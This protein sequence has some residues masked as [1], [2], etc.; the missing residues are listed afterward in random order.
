MGRYEM[1]REVS[2]EVP[3]HA[4]ISGDKQIKALVLVEC[5]RC[6]AMV[7]EDKLQDHIAELH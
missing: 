2:L 5:D 7:P 1:G 3:V 4:L 6:F